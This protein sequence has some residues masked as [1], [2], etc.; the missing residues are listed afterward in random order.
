VKPR[1]PRDLCFHDNQYPAHFTEDQLESAYAA[2][3]V[4]REWYEALGG[5]FATG[6]T[7][8]NREPVMVRAWR[9][10]ALEPQQE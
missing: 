10:Q 1:I 2:M 7:M 5:Y 8:A 6:G 4:K 9:Q 3:S